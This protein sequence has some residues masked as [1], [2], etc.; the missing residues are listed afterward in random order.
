MAIPEVNRQVPGHSN[1]QR[2]ISSLS[3][4]VPRQKPIHAFLVRFLGY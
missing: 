4:G 1:L 2:R 3:A